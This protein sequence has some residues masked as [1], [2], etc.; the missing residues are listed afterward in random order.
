MTTRCRRGTWS[1]SEYRGRVRVAHAVAQDELVVSPPLAESADLPRSENN[2][3]GHLE[4]GS[5]S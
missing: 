2:V 4:G 5:D 3:V 1:S